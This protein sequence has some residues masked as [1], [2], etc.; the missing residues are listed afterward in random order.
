MWNKIHIY[1][2]L[3]Y[4]KWIKWDYAALKYLKTIY[5]RIWDA[6]YVRKITVSCLLEDD[7]YYEKFD[8]SENNF[9][10]D[11]LY[12]SIYLINKILNLVKISS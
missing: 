12:L 10:H 1:E 4:R 11:L 6:P 5:I 2:E 3:L 9:I 7:Y 8:H